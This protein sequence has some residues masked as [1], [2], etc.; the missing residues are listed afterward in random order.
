M[1]HIAI[2]GFGFAGNLTLAHLVRHAA[3]LEIYLIDPNIDARGVAYGTR[4]PQHLLNVRA[5]NMSAFPEAPDDFVRWLQACQLPYGPTD[6]VPRMVYGDYLDHVFVQSQQLAQQHGHQIRLVPSLAV[7]VEPGVVRT[8]RGDAIAVDRIVL[9]TG[10]EFKAMPTTLP[11]VQN[12]WAEGAL[13][14]AAQS[15]GPI[16]LLGSG[17]TAVDV[18][19]ALR[20]E[21]Y[22]GAIT[23]RS[24]HGLLPQAHWDTSAANRYEAHALAGLQGLAAWRRWLRA[25]TRQCSNWRNVV[26]GLRPF[27]QAAWQRFST[28]EKQRFFARLASYWGVHRH[29]MAPSIAAAVQAELAQG[30]LRF[31]RREEGVLAI[32]CTGPQLDVRK[33]ARPLMM[34]LLS[35]G[36]IEPHATSIGIAV[37]AQHRAWGAAYPQLYAIGSLMTG[38]LLES[39][40]VPELR[41]QAQTIAEAVCTSS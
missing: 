38:Q 3:P 1:R 15:P 8:E 28:A 41:V 5:N 10:N 26:D 25:Q 9:A 40:A 12:P 39:T 31:S 20:A 6:F 35:G 17:L 7:A 19:L 37:D 32:N 22:G 18:L 33:S 16:Q 21:G 23:L 24:R 36:L 30:S 11:M 14:E 27:T 34:N 4:Y 2:I 13:A 29:R